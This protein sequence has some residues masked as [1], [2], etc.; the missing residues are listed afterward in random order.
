M[1]SRRI[2]RTKVLQ[3][4][5]AYYSSEER[6]IN[7]T[8]KELFFCI[9]KTY[10]LYHYLLALVIEIA[11]YAETRIELKRN[12]HQPTQEEAVFQ[13]ETQPSKTTVP[14]AEEEIIIPPI[15]DETEQMGIDEYI[16]SDNDDS[17]I[18]EEEAVTE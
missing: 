10:D 5:Y 7:N 12:K 14:V 3:V 11:D 6:S 13:T 2:I 9:H 4:L 8:E 1:I 16:N 17:V 18:I 15:V